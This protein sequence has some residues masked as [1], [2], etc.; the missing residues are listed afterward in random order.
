MS[1]L[2]CPECGENVSEY[3][4]KCLKCGCPIEIIKQKQPKIEGHIYAII[5]GIEYDVTEVVNLLLIYHEKQELNCP[6]VRKAY[7][8]IRKEYHIPAGQ[9][10]RAFD[11]ETM[12][13][14]EINCDPIRNSTTQSAPQPSNQVTCPKCGSTSIATTNRGYSFF[15]GF[16]GS[17]KPVNVCQKCGYKWKPGK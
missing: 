2:K 5:N 1:L 16:L 6:E 9:F 12:T 4:E 15:T 14:A 8:I 7:N 13:V 11:R 10:E 17:G 3:A